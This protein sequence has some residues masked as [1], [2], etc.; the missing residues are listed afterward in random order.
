M[1]ARRY[2]AVTVPKLHRTTFGRVFSGLMISS[3]R[4]F[5]SAQPSKLHRQA[6]IA[7]K[8]LVMPLEPR[9]D[10]DTDKLLWKTEELEE[11]NTIATMN[12]T[13]TR[14][15]LREVKTR[16]SKTDSRTPA[17]FRRVKNI[18]HDA[19]AHLATEVSP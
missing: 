13:I 6:I 3:M 2:A 10:F 7:E 5:K 8:K 16:C 12:R 9:N 4:K 17:Q 18:M 1:L 11:T 14:S 19:A 15:S